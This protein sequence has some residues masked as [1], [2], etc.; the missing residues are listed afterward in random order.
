MATDEERLVVTL[1]ARVRDFERNFARAQQTSDKRLKSIED[2]AKKSASTLAQT[3]SQLG[4]NAGAAFGTIGA[5]AGI[6]SL[7]IAGLVAGAR[8]ASAEIAQMAAEAQK[9]GV[10]VEAFQELG[11]AAQ[12]A[13]V[14]IDGLTDGLKEMQLRADEYIVTGQGSAAEAFKRL[15]LSVDDVKTKLA[16]P[17]GFFQ[18]IIDQ[19]GKLD[20]A[21]QIRIADE[22]FGGTGGEQ[23][24]RFLSQGSGYIARMRQEARDTGNVLDAELVQRA[25]QIDREFAK[26]TTTIGNNLKWALVSVVGLMRDFTGMLNTTEKQSAETLKRR[27]DLLTAA[28]DNMQKSSSAFA[29]GGGQAGIDQRRAEAAALQAEL[30]KR[31][32]TSITLNKPA[33]GSRGDLSQIGAANQL[34]KAY[35][36]IVLSAE[37]RI[38]QMGVEQQAIGLTTAE[39]ERLRV[40]QELLAEVQRAGITLTAEQAAKLDEL[41]TR[42]GQAAGALE[43]AAVSQARL[44]ETLDTVRGTSYDVLSG[45]SQD[46]RNGISLTDALDNALNTVLD[47]IIDISLQNAIKGLFGASGTTQTGSLG[48]LISSFFGGFKAE[49]GPVSAGKAYVVGERGPEMI[50]PSSASYVIPNHQLGSAAGQSRASVTVPIEITIDARGADEA[51]LARVEKQ[52]AQLRREVP[53][54]A[55]RGVLEARRRNASV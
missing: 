32:T 31:P 22:I 55:V 2:R 27:I 7:G 8:R 3:F 25:I 1:E 37:Q 11:Y 49:G 24:V 45:F 42:S 29:I 43:Q 35:D 47:T 41:A 48:G 33:T 39:A 26:L 38:Q 52:I 12:G 19:L 9:A 10:G 16:D 23:F 40:K 28:A 6:G 51:G 20:T 13:L 34:A 15:G 14:N 21:S 50:V 17:A 36:G 18:E 5:A 44:I 4:K 53:G 46:L 30:D 54:M